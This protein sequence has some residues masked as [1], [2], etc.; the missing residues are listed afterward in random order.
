M[1]F[2]VL[3]AL[4]LATFDPIHASNCKKP[5]FE[6]CSCGITDYLG[7][8]Q[9]VVNCTDTG[10]TNAS[11]LQ[12]LP[13]ETQVLIYTGN[14][15]SELPWNLFGNDYSHDR[16]KIV[17][18]SNNRI[19][20]IRGKT[21]H[22]VR[23]VERL[24]LNY[25]QINLAF[26]GEHPRLFSNFE[27][28]EA[29]H[30]TNAFNTSWTSYEN[31][32]LDLGEIFRNSNLTKLEKLHLEQNQILNFETDPL[33]FCELKNLMD[34]HLGNNNLTHIKFKFAC[35]ERL[36][37]IDFHANKITN[38]NENDRHLLD[39]LPQRNQS[40]IIDVSENPLSCDDIDSLY[41][42]F[43]DTK[44]T[45]QSKEKIQCKPEPM[46]GVTQELRVARVEA[47]GSSG[48]VTFLS[49]ALCMSLL[50]LLYTNREPIRNTVYP[51]V[52]SLSRNIQYT[53]IGRSEAQEMD[54]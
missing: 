8:K 53:T 40:L 52:L 47:N 12:Y 28:L 36:R 11:M 25:N 54:V 45:I 6:K 18:L 42:W 7:N 20:T 29:L 3:L 19:K 48:T 14:F 1:F 9:Y 38:L 2:P 30:L 50:A 16:L 32:A 43:H 22:H 41:D 51:Y 39:A 26:T 5:H 17:D 4:L 15:I 24:I 23:N 35:L 33:L 49:I 37:Y 10:Y 13:D 21:F 44:V 31:F 27:N 34:L 46:I